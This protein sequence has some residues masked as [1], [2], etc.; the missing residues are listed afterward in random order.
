MTD[1]GP[2]RTLFDF[3]R[4]WSRRAH[5]AAD[6][7]AAQ[8]RLVLVTGAVDTLAGRG[9]VPTVN[10]VA[11]EIG[12]D[13]SGVSR[14]A[15][16]AVDAGYLEVRAAAK[17]ARRRHLVLTP[18]GSAMLGEAHAW[19]ERVFG[20]LTADWDEG[21]RAEF[22]RSMTDLLERSHLVGSPPVGRDGATG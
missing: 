5:S 14:L 11:A 20:L 6:P 8:G 21:R 3:V 1:P 22:H 4:H 19:Q 16:S 13:Q 12:L 7:L 15:R 9:E 18:A 10:A 17:D 2:G